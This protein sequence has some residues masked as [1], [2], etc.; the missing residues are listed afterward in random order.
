M[1]FL[2]PPRPQVI[3]QPSAPA[4]PEA[5]PQLQAPQGSRP[6]R[7]SMTPTF[8]GESAAPAPT[9]PTSS[10]GANTLLGQ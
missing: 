3:V 8:L 5:A 4:A 1:G 10:Q 7:R 6:R 2:N 9:S